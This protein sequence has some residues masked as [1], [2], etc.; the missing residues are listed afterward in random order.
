VLV[1]TECPPGV[2][3]Q[4]VHAWFDAARRSTA[5]P[6]CLVSTFRPYGACCEISVS[7][8]WIFL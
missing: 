2:R 8:E 3:I 5:P 1:P 4:V 7:R 6:P